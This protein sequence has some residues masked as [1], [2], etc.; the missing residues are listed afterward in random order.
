MRNL[1]TGDLTLFLDVSSDLQ[2]LKVS[3][4]EGLEGSVPWWI[5]PPAPSLP[6]PQLRCLIKISTL[7][8]LTM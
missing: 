2:S 4:E 8:V 3:P 6:S 1:D 7:A 5:I